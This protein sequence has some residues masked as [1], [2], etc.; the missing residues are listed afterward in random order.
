LPLEIK[1]GL[2]AGFF[3]YLT[4]PLDVNKFL[5]AVDA[6]LAEGAWEEVETPARQTERGAAV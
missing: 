1:R 6:A 3:R 4:K 5:G 2:E